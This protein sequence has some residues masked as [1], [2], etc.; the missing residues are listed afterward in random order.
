MSEIPYGYCHCGCGEKTRPAETTDSRRGVV[1]GEPRKYLRHHQCR[2]NGPDRWQVDPGTGCWV[3]QW[4]IDRGGYGV[5]MVGGRTSIAHR[6]IYEQHRGPIP[7]GL[8]L[9][10]LC[11]N[12]ACVNPAHLEPVT[13]AEN[14]RR[15]DN[16]KLTIE[17]ARSIRREV[18][19]ATCAEVAAR[20][21][22]S[23]STVSHIATRRR[24]REDAA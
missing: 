4:R 2:K 10:H 19:A 5:T 14:Q 12:R 13:N 22:V 8:T 24:W 7:E 1:K 18:R 20:Y 6:V 9:D 21:G 16:A 3:W 11:R 17:Q 23:P 15:G